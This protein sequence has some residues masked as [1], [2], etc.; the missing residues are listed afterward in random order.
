[1]DLFRSSTG[2][3]RARA[4]AAALRA[5]AGRAG[6]R[7]LDLLAPGFCRE[8]GAEAPGAA[9]FCP[10][11]AARIRWIITACPRCGAPSPNPGPGE[12]GECAGRGLS[13][14]RAA[15]AAEYTGPWRTAILRFKYLGD[16]G[17]GGLLGEAVER[18]RAAQFSSP[19]AP[20]IVPVPPHPWRKLARGRDPVEELARDLGVRARLEVRSVLRRAK[21]IPS[22]TSLPRARRLGNPSGA[23][24]VRFG[25][26]PRRGR[27]AAPVPPAILLLD[28]V[29]TTGAT[30]S[31]CARALKEA[32]A[33]SVLVIAAARSLA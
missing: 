26:R 4:L 7:A 33:R 16:Q 12:C 3:R 25:Y 14:D 15:A 23:Y 28:D 22:Q 19:P 2:A 1:M 13:F 11:C 17:V 8:C 5:L 18:V 20:V 30:V 6:S 9:P 27:P 31:E 21:W 10:P 29:L 24:R 32:G